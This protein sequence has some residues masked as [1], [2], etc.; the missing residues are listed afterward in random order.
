MSGEGKLLLDEGACP[1]GVAMLR[2]RLLSGTLLRAER[3]AAVH[4]DETQVASHSEKEPAAPIYRRG[5]GF[6]TIH[7]RW[8]TAPEGPARRDP[9]TGQCRLH[10][11]H[12]LRR[13]HRIGPG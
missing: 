12:G 8:A 10:H 1:A 11:R 3:H 7:V 6:H 2:A 5:F 4:I 9:A 13:D